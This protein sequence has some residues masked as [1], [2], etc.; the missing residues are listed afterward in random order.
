M[1]ASMSQW[2]TLSRAAHLPG[3][4]R[5][6]LQKRIREG[7]LRSFDGMVAADDLQRTLTRHHALFESL[8][9]RLA[10]ARAPAAAARRGPGAGAGRPGARR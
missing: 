7:E 8:H 2:L 4:S 3:V 10:E 1:L 9:P 5:I 6:A